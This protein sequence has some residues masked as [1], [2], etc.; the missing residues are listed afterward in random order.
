MR[1]NEIA[2]FKWSHCLSFKLALWISTIYILVVFQHFPSNLTP[3]SLS[4]TYYS[5]KAGQT[6]SFRMMLLTNDYFLTLLYLL[7]YMGVFGLVQTREFCLDGVIRPL[8]LCVPLL[9]LL[10]GKVIM[11]SFLLYVPSPWSRSQKRKWI[12][13][14][15]MTIRSIY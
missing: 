1:S 13:R 10:K 11:S 14:G 4:Q 5:S 3:T 9:L 8:H 2:N 7:T 12:Q 6:S 15:Q